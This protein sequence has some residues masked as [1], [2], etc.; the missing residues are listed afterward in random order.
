MTYEKHVFRII[1]QLEL[2]GQLKDVM[3]VFAGRKAYITLSYRED[4]THRTRVSSTHYVA[5]R[6]LET[7]TLV[8]TCI[9]YPN[10]S[11]EDVIKRLENA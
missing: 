8:K 10:Q 3:R 1:N 7:S 6:L 5:R 4:G 11:L 2:Y 9:K